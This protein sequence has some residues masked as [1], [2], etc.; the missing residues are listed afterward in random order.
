MSDLIY[1]KIYAKIKEAKNILLVTHER[2]D[3]DAVASVCAMAELLNSLGVT[4]N[5]YSPGPVPFQ[6]NFIPHM[7]KVGIDKAAFDYKNFDYL[8]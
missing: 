2:P 6:F 4:Y 7:K 3:I 1:T 8:Y 5:I